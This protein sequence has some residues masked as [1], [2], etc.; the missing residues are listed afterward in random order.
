MYLN[1][2]EYSALYLEQN[3]LPFSVIEALHS[4]RVLNTKK[5]ITSSMDV[6]IFIGREVTTVLKIAVDNAILELYDSCD[7]FAAL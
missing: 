1:F 7:Y 2:Y 5:P 6:A 3:I 4:K